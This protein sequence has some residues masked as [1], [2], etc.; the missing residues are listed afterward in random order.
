[1]FNFPNDFLQDGFL[2]GLV[3]ITVIV[4]ATQERRIQQKQPRNRYSYSSKQ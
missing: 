4:A 3:I 2:L 1:M